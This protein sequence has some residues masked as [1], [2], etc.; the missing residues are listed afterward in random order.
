MVSHDV[1]SYVHTNDMFVGHLML[2]PPAASL[3]GP[4]AMLTAVRDMS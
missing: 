1:S 2:G 3:W 4:M